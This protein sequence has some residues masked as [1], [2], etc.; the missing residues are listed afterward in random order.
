M[1]ALKSLSNFRRTL[2]MLLINCEISLQ[3]N[4]S[5]D[6]FLVPGF[7]ANQVSELKINDAK[8]YVSLVNLETQD[9][10]R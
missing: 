4:C 5:K 1:V 7:L 6:R 10:V 9:N 2:E 8:L 3:L